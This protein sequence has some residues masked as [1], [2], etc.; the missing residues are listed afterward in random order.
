M[1]DS[2]YVVRS[3][4]MGDIE[5]LATLMVESWQFAYEGL[6]PADFLMNLSVQDRAGSLRRVLESNAASD[7]RDTRLVVSADKPDEI[8]G[9]CSFGPDRTDDSVGEVYALYV[10]PTMIGS[11]LGRFLMQDAVARLAEAG[12]GRVNLWV[13]EGN[14]RAISFYEK[15]GFRL[16]GKTKAEN[17]GTV[18]LRELQM[19]LGLAAGVL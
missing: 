8:L 6:M 10:S 1:N 16:T 5:A 19:S 18:E 13:L 14:E 3:A 11:G 17:L 4:V 2:G 12:F 9:V 7:L 15:A